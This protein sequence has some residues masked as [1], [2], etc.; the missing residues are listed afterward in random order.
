V[1]EDEAIA[2]SGFIKATLGALENLARDTDKQAV[3]ASL[4]ES[5]LLQ[6]KISVRDI[7]EHLHD[8][9][10]VSGPTQEKEA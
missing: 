10:N 5:K 1:N 3:A 4:L 8:Y 6:L 9:F 7:A 2:Q